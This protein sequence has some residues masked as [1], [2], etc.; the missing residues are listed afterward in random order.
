MSEYEEIK[1]ELS[2]LRAEV[3]KGFAEMKKWR[4]SVDVATKGDDDHDVWGYKQKISYNRQQIK[5][6]AEKLSSVETKVNKIIW[7][8]IGAAS[9]AGTAAAVIFNVITSFI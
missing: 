8:A 5:D 1:Q 4:A 3:R 9:V 7:T 2:E 6:Q